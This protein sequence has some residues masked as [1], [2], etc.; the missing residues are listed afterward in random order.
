[1]LDAL[2]E[3]QIRFGNMLE[4]HH[5]SK[6]AAHRYESTIHG[7]L[8]YVAHTTIDKSSLMLYLVSE[9]FLR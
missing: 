6:K 7:D 4:G 9:W 3:T 8:N 1:M 2:P 5:R